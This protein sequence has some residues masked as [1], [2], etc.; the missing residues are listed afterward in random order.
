MYA[1]FNAAG[2]LTQEALLR[3][4]CWIVLSTTD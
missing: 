1:K 2:K 3:R 4:N